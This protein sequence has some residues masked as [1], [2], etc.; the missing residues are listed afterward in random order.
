MSTENK[1]VKGEYVTN[2]KTGRALKVGSRVWI[3][4][5]KE[6]ILKDVSYQDPQVFEE[7]HEEDS[8]QDVDVKIQ[9]INRR[10]PKNQQAV[11]GRGKYANKIV[12]RNTT[13]S[14]KDVVHYTARKSA[15]VM[16][17]N[18]VL[19]EQEYDMEKELENLILSEIMTGHVNEGCEVNIKK[20][21]VKKEVDN[22]CT[23]DQE[24][25]G[26][27]DEEDEEEDY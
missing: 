6:G 2:P 26:D 12:K 21:R 9:T 23:K 11:R 7:V 20:R 19:D 14:V 15:K 17:E 25:D 18:H 16:V 24:E 13:P 5:V 10:L 3:N 1:L 22:Y 4:L 8:E 27:E